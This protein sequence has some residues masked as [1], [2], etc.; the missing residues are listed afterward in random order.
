MNRRQARSY[1]LRVLAAEARHHIG[2]GS[3]WIERPLNSDNISVQEDGTF[4]DADQERIIAEVNAVADE[5]ERRSRK[6]APTSER[7]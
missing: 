4:S 1:V 5:L 7:E 6:L 2:N 3:E